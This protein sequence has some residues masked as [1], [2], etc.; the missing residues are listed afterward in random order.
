MDAFIPTLEQMAVLFL[1][2]SAGYILVKVKIL[3]AS[4][5]T[6]LARLVNNVF[7][8]ANILVTFTTYCNIEELK[9]QWQIILASGCLLVVLIIISII[10]SKLCTKDGYLRKIYTYALSFSNFAFMGYAVVGAIFPPEI[11]F[12][13][14]IFTLPFWIMIYAWGAPVLLMGND[15][16]GKELLPRKTRVKQRVKSFINPL[17]ISM[18]IGIILGITEVKLPKFLNSFIGMSSN[19]MSPCA[20]IL[21]GITVSTISLKKTF[22]DWNIYL[23]SAIKLI[24]YPALFFVVILI[25]PGLDKTIVVCCMVMCAMPTGLNTIVIPSAYGKDTSFAGGL[26]IVSH[27]LSCITIP[28]VFC[29]I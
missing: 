6:V 29:L 25:F 9:N 15:E 12:A 18:I 19:C 21:T 17:F 24:L 7:L 22:T 3:N 16:K 4:A 2:I 23:V 20:M 14:K 13:Y 27:I 26:A 8:P 28:L 1:L 5:S 10:L 11:D